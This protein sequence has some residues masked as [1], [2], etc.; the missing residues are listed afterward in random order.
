MELPETC[1]IVLSERR[2]KMAKLPR[3]ADTTIKTYKGKV[4]RVN[5]DEGVEF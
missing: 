4:T 5:F 2:A 3:H 1:V